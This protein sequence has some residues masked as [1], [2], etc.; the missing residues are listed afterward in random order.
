MKKILYTVLFFFTLQTAFAQEE[1]PGAARLK[2]KM[3]EY[4]QNKLGLNK[5]EAERFQPLFMDYLRQLRTT[6]Q[7]FKND[8]LVLQQKVIE[9]RLR[10]RDQ[11]KPV[12]G[13]KRSNDV[14]TYEREFVEKVQD[15]RNERLQERH[16]G[17]A[18]KRNGPDL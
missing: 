14:F 6:K 10:F 8:R 18:N 2:E 3:V 17:R 9:V 5:S 12:I 7:E 16:D 1:Q 13:E 11:V 4:I 15:I